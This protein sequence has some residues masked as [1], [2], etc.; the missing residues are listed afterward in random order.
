MKTTLKNNKYSATIL[1]K[2]AELV[3]FKKENINYIWTIDEQFW[4]KT[5]PVLFPIVGR[6]KDDSYSINGEEFK[7]SRHGFARDYEFK[8]IE[9]TDKFV[10]F[11]LNENEETFQKFPFKFE[12]QL[13]YELVGN[14]LTLTYIVV[15][16]SKTI[17]PFNIGAHPAFSIL[18]N[19]ENFS[20]LFNNDEKLTSHLLNDD[21]FS[22]ETFE[23]ETKEKKINLSFDLFA[24]DALVFK[25]LNSTE[26]QILNQNKPYLKINF[27]G[28]PYLGIWTKQNAPFLCIEPWQGYADL[29]NATGNI[30]EKEAIQVLKLNDKFTSSFSIEIE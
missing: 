16:N 11:S 20:L 1:H 26:I 12:L 17:M 25:S 23:V 7:M 2:G 19:F 22:G 28:F 8:V 27:E 10:V 18:G 21:L 3:E 5:S 4:N 13:K 24:K 30:F 29:E 9:K 14:K 15:N 6:L